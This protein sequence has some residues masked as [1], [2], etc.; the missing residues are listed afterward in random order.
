M[1]LIL[2]LLLSD[3]V[4]FHAVLTAY[5]SIP[6]ESAVLF[7]EVLLNEGEGSVSHMFDS[8]HHFIHI[9]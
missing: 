8:H 7:N 1:E 5:S 3:T 6:D 4:A 2:N 9:F